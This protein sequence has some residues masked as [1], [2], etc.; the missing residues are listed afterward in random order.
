MT[1]L[2]P[3]ILAA[4]LAAP[5][6]AVAAAPEPT[7]AVPASFY[8]GKWYEIARLP[9]SNQK[10]CEGGQ[11]EFKSGDKS[12][13]FSVVQSCHL[14]ALT[15]RLKTYDTTGQILPSTR[16]AKFQMTFLGGVVKQEYWVID[17]DDNL[18]WAVMGTP[19]GN[20]VWL[21]ARKPTLPAAQKTAIVARLKAAGYKTDKLIFPQQTA[22]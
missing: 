5:L 19:G 10:D 11:T 21:L 6:A 16:N 4:V 13:N 2:R 1:S 17:R 12:A 7:K 22:G 9:N 15:G 3:L 14:G 18:G 8:S 20:Y